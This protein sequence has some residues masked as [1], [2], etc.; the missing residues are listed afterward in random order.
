MAI[1]TEESQRKREYH[2]EDLKKQRELPLDFLGKP[3]SEFLTLQGVGDTWDENWRREK[4]RT[5]QNWVEQY[6]PLFPKDVQKALTGVANLAGMMVHED[7][8]KKAQ[9]LAAVEASQD[10]LSVIKKYA[11]E[12]EKNLLRG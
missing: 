4:A 6:K 3:K 2:L 10:N 7:G 8:M 1:D 11:E 9:H 12:V 5:V